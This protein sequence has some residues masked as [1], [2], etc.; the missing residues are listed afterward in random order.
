[1]KLI[2]EK[3]ILNML[4]IGRTTLNRWRADADQGFPVPIRMHRKSIRWI[5]ADIISY[6]ES[7]KLQQ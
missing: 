4:A 2:T 1:M 7:R 3:D 5:E 6:I